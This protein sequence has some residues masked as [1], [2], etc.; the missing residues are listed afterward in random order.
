MPLF[1]HFS[2]ART[3]SVVQNWL[4][5]SSDPSRRA[6]LATLRPTESSGGDL[7]N[8]VGTEWSCMMEIQAG[9]GILNPSKLQ[10]A[11]A[12]GTNQGCASNEVMGCVMSA[13]FRSKRGR[14]SWPTT[15]SEFVNWHL[16]SISLTALPCLSHYNRI[17]HLA[18]HNRDCCSLASL[19][20]TLW[21]N[22]NTRSNF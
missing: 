2:A 19:R 5:A 20:N 18:V 17:S 21:K 7:T 13:F 14:R 6:H 4:N 1:L 12:L 8:W 16:T 3:I 10:S 15:V 9:L 11:T 22:E